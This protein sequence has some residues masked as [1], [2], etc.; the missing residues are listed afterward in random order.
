LDSDEFMI[1][2][3]PPGRALVA[4]ST[5]LKA[6][7]PGQW[8]HVAG[9]VDF[10]AESVIPYLDGRTVRKGGFSTRPA[11]D[12]SDHPWRIGIHNPGSSEWRWAAKGAIDSV[13]V[14]DRALGAGEIE[15]LHAS[16]A[17][18]HGR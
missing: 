10:S 18:A 16:E 15:R 12:P 2:V 17:S 13:R 5:G 8:H 11:G 6:G 9:V 3:R 4:V 7:G 14:Y 1:Q